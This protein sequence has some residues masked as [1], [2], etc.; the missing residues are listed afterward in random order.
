M[1]DLQTTDMVEWI[2]RI[3]HSFKPKFTPYPTGSYFTHVSKNNEETWS[4]SLCDILEYRKKVGGGLILDETRKVLY[5]DD[6]I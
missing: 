5:Y 6:E 3:L 1:E 4:Y 2:N